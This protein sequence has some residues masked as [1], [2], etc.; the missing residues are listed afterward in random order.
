[1][2][3]V[4]YSVEIPDLT[5]WKRLIKCQHACP[6]HTDARGYIQAIVR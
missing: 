4:R 3:L 1:M 6:V 5:Y 2:D